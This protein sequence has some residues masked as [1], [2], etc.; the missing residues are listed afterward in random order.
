MKAITKVSYFKWILYMTWTG[1][2]RCNSKMYSTIRALFLKY[3]TTLPS[4]APVERLFDLSWL[5]II[6]KWEISTLSRLSCCNTTDFTGVL[7]CRVGESTHTQSL[8]LSLLL[9]LTHA[10]THAHTHTHTGSLSRSL[11]HSHTQTHCPGLNI[12]LEHLS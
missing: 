3:N 1:S 9:S 4:S 5:H 10:R 12:P 11:T 2:V 7:T 6:T 8:S